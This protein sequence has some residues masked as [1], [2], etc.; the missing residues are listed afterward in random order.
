MEKK[1]NTYNVKC[2]KVNTKGL[3]KKLQ[4]IQAISAELADIMADYV[5]AVND[6]AT[7][8]LTFRFDTEDNEPEEK[9]IFSFSP[10]DY[11]EEFE[12]EEFED[13]ADISE[14]PFALCDD[15]EGLG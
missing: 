12:P 5:A 7:T 9:D 8:P 13:G 1:L 14:T 6:L 4:V 11:P 2:I 15:V 10:Y 3:E